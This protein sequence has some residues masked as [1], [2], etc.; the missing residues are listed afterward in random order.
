MSQHSAISARGQ[1]SLSI[2]QWR[3]SQPRPWKQQNRLIIC[4]HAKPNPYTP[5]SGT[6]STDG[7][8]PEGH[9]QLHETLYDGNE[10]AAQVHQ[11]KDK[12]RFIDGEDDGSSLVPLGEFLAKRSGSERAPP[13]G[14]YAI[15]DASRALQYVSYS[16]NI[17]LAAKSRLEAVGEEKCAFVRNMVFANTAMQTRQA[18]EAQQSNWINEHGTV[19]PGNGIEKDVWDVPFNVTAMSDKERNVYHAKREKMV[20]AM[21]EVSLSDSSSDSDSSLKNADDDFSNRE[22]RA[23]D[24]KSAVEENDWSAVIEQQT[25]EATGQEEQ[26]TITTPFVGAHVHRSIGSSTDECVEEM[27]KESV[28]AALDEVR[29]YLMAD[30]GDVEVVAVEDGRI[31]LQLQGAC[32]SC[33]ASSSTMK[34]GIERC[35]LA[36][37]GDQVKEVIEVGGGVE[38][39][40]ATVATVDAHINGLRGAIDAYGGAVEVRTVNPPT[41]ELLYTGPKPLAYGLVAAVKDKFPELGDIRVIDAETG[42][43][44]EF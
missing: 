24:L 34:M 42:E 28:H 43:K 18:L 20:A 7:N 15:Y 13:V 31:L 6:L 36:K 11:S 38:K 37:F 33:P 8:I 44:I 9:Q 3:H 40:E 17:V 19:P 32:G 26:G 14:V 27:N 4:F 21:G 16:R 41:A 1:A 29:P 25:R 2:S 22:E 5:S 12:Y 30:G 10:S 39:I 35:L 23:A